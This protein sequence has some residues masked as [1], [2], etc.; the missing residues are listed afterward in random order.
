MV[1][2]SQRSLS[3]Q[4]PQLH[5]PEPSG[6]DLRGAGSHFTRSADLS[7]NR[8]DTRSLTPGGSSPCS[9]IRHISSLKRRENGGRFSESEKELASSARA[10]HDQA[11]SPRATG[12]A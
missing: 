1:A 5:S 12:G 9:A 2:P 3:L 4:Q 7:R 11:W 8:S 10:S 6:A